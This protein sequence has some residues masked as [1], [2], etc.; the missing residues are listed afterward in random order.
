MKKQSCMLDGLKYFLMIYFC[1]PFQLCPYTKRCVL[2]SYGEAA[3]SPQSTASMFL[4]LCYSW[5]VFKVLHVPAVVYLTFHVVFI[6]ND[7]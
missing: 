5:D 7:L 1:Q 3:G 4:Q 2:L 6:V